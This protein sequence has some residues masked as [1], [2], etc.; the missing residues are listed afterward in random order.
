MKYLIKIIAVVLGLLLILGC[1]GYVALALYLDYWSLV[2]MPSHPNYAPFGDGASIVIPVDPQEVL[3]IGS[4]AQVRDLSVTVNKAGILTDA[5]DLEE[6]DDGW[7]Y[8]WVHVTI[9]SISA[10]KII[11]VNPVGES[12]IQGI[13]LLNQNTP[14][15][16]SDFGEVTIDPIMRVGSELA[17]GGMIEGSIIY[18]VPLENELYW[19]YGESSTDNAIFRVR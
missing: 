1:L 8:W 15:P 4:T 13:L 14:Y 3:S 6:L 12:R 11:R 10:E 16:Y 9:R 19:I 5:V 7:V 18:K 2:V 17:P